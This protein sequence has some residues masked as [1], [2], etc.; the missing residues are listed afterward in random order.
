MTT[1]AADNISVIG[2]WFDRNYQMERHTQ[3][4]LANGEGGG[5]EANDDD[6]AADGDSHLENVF[7]CFGVF[8]SKRECQ[9]PMNR[10]AFDIAR[11]CVWVRSMWAV[12]PV[13]LTPILKP[14]HLGRTLHFNIMSSVSSSSRPPATK[15]CPPIHMPNSTMKKVQAHERTMAQMGSK[16]NEIII[17]R[18]QKNQKKWNEIGA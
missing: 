9:K 8:C 10:C 4:P 17:Q 14:F 5:G 11:R 15:S 2:H 7:L 1:S 18:A 13:H 16:L 3:G 12:Q 6:D